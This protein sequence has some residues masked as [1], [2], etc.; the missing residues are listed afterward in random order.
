[1]YLFVM[2]PCATC[3]A[4]LILFDLITLIIGYIMKNKNHEAPQHVLF[5]ILLVLCLQTSQSIFFPYG[6]WPVLTSTPNSS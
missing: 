4:H 1:L 5:S 3:P 6:E 2:T